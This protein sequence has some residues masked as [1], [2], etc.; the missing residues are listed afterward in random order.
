[1]LQKSCYSSLEQKKPEIKIFRRQLLNFW[2]MYCS[3]FMTI[4]VQNKNVIP[5]VA[6]TW[7]HGRS[8]LFLITRGV[9][10]IIQTRNKHIGARD[11]DGLERRFT[12]KIP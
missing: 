6:A 8:G 2:E 7:S 3:S 9:F 12:N 4:S 5:G 1:M 10:L 11:N